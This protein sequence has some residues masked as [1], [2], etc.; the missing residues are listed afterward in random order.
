MSAGLFVYESCEDIG[1]NCIGAGI[2][3]WDEIPVEFELN[4]TEDQTYFIVISTWAAPQFTPYDLVIQEVFC[5]QPE[6]LPA[7]NIGETSADLSWTNPSGATSWQ[8]VIQDPADDLPAGAGTT[9]ATNTNYTAT[10]TFDGQPLETAT[11]YEY[12]VRAAC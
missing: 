12:Y 10:Q 8:I 11:L 9:I 4:V 3:D 6:E 7:T 5:D 1:V 2:F